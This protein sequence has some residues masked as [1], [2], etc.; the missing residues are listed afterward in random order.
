MKWTE[1]VNLALVKRDLNTMTLR[2]PNNKLV[3]YVILQIFPFTSETRRMG[4]IVKVCYPTTVV[5]LLISDR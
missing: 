1:D 4:I 3:T 5:Y 2:T